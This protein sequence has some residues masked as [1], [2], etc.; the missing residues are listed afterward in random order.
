MVPQAAVSDNGGLAGVAYSSH[1]QSAVLTFESSFRA[2]TN[3]FPLA[4]DKPGNSP[5]RVGP[6]PNEAGQP[7]TQRLAAKPARNS[8]G[9]FENAERGLN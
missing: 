3:T 8:A 2:P 4:D 1:L 6:A 5:T 7:D 9:G